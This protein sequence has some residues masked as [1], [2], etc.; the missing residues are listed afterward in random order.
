MYPAA[1]AVLN[2]SGVKRWKTGHPW[3][4]RAGIEVVEE[5]TGREAVARVLTP[6]RR[7]LGW[8]MLSRESQIT[9]RRL[10]TQDPPDRAYLRGRIAAAVETRRARLPGR[11]AYRAVFGESDGLPGL[12]VD[13]YGEHLVAQFLTWG[14]DALRNEVV[15][16]LQEV[17]APKSILGRNDT[18]VR[19]HEG[20]PLIVTELAGSVPETAVYHEGDLEFTA[21]PRHGQKTGAFLDQVD[22]HLRAGSLARGRVLDLFTYAGGFALAAA[23]NAAQVT[24]VDTSAGTLALAAR[25]A[26]ANRIDSVL[27]Q[28][29]NV[30]DYLRD[31]D[32]AGDRFDVVILD[33]P[34]FAKSKSDLP[35]ALRGYK[36]INLRAMKILDRGG[37]LVTCSCSYHMS[38]ALLMEVLERAAADA[39]RPFRV[40]E[41]R[42]AGPDHPV[43]LGFP[44]SEYLKCVV[45]E[46]LE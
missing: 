12:V 33:P 44:E 25:H 31:R 8:A 11:D 36:E 21:D 42:G 20:L 9:L 45:L 13:R 14:M 7:D 6:T 19:R 26:A 17:L 10:D 38:P 22:N 32:R 30:F 16:L 35:G 18:P 1:D 23:R 27:F 34:A 29:A 15:A 24:A 46:V 39:R 43:R 41:R 2:A 4:Y 3:I 28:E 40:V 5:E 37:I